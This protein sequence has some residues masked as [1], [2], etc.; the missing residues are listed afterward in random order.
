MYVYISFKKVVP[1]NQHRELIE[2]YFSQKIAFFRDH[3][4]QIYYFVLVLWML[5]QK[6]SKD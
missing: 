5:K 3:V 1:C 4:L 6:H 2:D